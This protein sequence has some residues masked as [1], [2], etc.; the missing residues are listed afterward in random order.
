MP[1]VVTC[2][3]KRAYLG[4]K[5]GPPNSSPVSPAVCRPRSKDGSDTRKGANHVLTPRPAGGQLGD[6]VAVLARQG[7]GSTRVATR[8]GAHA[9]RRPHRATARRAVPRGRTRSI[10][11]EKK[12]RE[13]ANMGAGHAREKRHGGAGASYRNAG[14][15][16]PTAL[17][18]GRQ[19]HHR[20]HGP[21]SRGWHAS[22]PPAGPRQRRRR[23]V[24]QRQSAATTARGHMRRAC[25]LL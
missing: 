1:A 25:P 4:I 10:P 18:A 2:C 8:K 22:K 5:R 23:T 24:G 3:R 17:A 9:P 16:G 13:H 19:A 20:G 6:A 7:M 11:L 15:P 14:R 21:L 12:R